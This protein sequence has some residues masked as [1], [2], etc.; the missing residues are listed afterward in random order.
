MDAVPEIKGISSELL[1][2]LEKLQKQDLFSFLPDVE[3]DLKL[4][5]LPQ[6]LPN[7]NSAFF[8][9][10]KDLKLQ[11]DLLDSLPTLKIGRKSKTIMQNMAE[12]EKL[13][14]NYRINRD[15][16][17]YEKEERLKVQEEMCPESTFLA[18]CCLHEKKGKKERQKS[19][20]KPKDFIHRN[21]ELA[22]AMA[23]L[24]L[25]DEEKHQLDQ[26]L[27]NLDDC[28]DQSNG[29][30]MCESD[31]QRL[32]EIDTELEDKYPES[33]HLRSPSKNALLDEALKEIDGKI[34]TVRDE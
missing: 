24:P 6:G 14:Q 21:I 18:L 13:E 31:K 27:A 19:P 28:G 32:A 4:P 34:A 22:T 1:E 5:P 7:F 2:K 12:I 26:L 30:Q 29:F 3:T 15:L 23:K 25:T 17:K 10:S 16:L 9:Y 20:L 8:N 11:F 33:R